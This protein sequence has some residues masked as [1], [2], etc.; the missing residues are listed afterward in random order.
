MRSKLCLA[1]QFPT[2]R[3]KS[4]AKRKFAVLLAFQPLYKGAIVFVRALVFNNPT[5]DHKFT[6]LVDSIY[7]GGISLREH[8]SSLF[9]ARNKTEFNVLLIDASE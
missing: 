9:S 8:I 3:H 6:T 5:L 2:R 1:N 7:R 4:A